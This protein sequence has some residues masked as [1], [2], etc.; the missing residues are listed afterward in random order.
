MKNRTEQEARLLKDEF[1]SLNSEKEKW[2]WLKG[3]QGSGLILA[4]DN[5]STEVM[6]GYDWDA[7]YCRHL[8]LLT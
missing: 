3:K 4:L 6:V 8:R 5:D 2:L 7:E 1:D